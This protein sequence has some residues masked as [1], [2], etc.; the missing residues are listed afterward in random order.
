MSTQKEK[1]TVK[2]TQNKCTMKVLL[3]SLQ[4]SV[5][6]TLPVHCGNKKREKFI[7]THFLSSPA[8]HKSI[9]PPI[10]SL[11]CATLW[12]FIAVVYPWRS[13]LHK[14]TRFKLVLKHFTEQNNC[15]EHL[16]T[17]SIKNPRHN[18][19]HWEST[20]RLSGSV[21]VVCLRE[22]RWKL[23]IAKPVDYLE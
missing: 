7:V 21:C 19:Q 3:G 22:N 20:W 9:F 23:L 4:W 5:E 18:V 15:T 10:F 16:G 12:R 1:K 6:L 14:R 8:L 13:W 17:V 11:C 2:Y